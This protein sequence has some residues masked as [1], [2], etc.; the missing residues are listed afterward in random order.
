MKSSRSA[1]K[2]RITFFFALTVNHANRTVFDVF[3]KLFLSA[4]KQLLPKT[5]LNS[6]IPFTFLMT[7]ILKS[8]WAVPKFPKKYSLHYFKDT[9]FEKFTVCRKISQNFFSFALTVNHANRTVFDVFEK[10]FLSAYKQLLPKTVLISKIPFTFLMT[11]IAKSWRSAPKILSKNI[12]AHYHKDIYSE[13]YRRR[14]E[15]P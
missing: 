12:S 3:E 15:F 10:L 1:A 9:Y 13:K 7:L 14:A 6:K 8:T 11:L 2:F 5:V 4:Y